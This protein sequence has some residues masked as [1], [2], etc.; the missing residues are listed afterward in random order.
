VVTSDAALAERLRSLRDHGRPS[1]SRNRH[2][3]I[4]TNS[5]LDALQA[6]VLSA[7]LPRLDAW[8]AARRAIAASYRSALG[9]G[10]A[11]LVS[12]AP[13]VHSVYHLAVARV[14]DRD[15]VRSWLERRGI[16]TGVHYPIPCHWQE[17]Y[18]RF[19]HETLPVAE[20]AA[21]EVLSLP[22]FPHM[23]EAQICR[24]CEALHDL[25]QEE[26]PAGVG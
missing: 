2:V 22:V 12:E 9:G 24:V 10:A 8:T 16:E 13:Q 21:A 7:K 23:T 6:A 26:V 11:R 4:A 3:E 17:P 25:F 1:G 5:R 20:R 18:R 15:G 14:R 19:A